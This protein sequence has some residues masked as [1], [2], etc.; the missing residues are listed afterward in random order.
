MINPARIPETALWVE[1]NQSA[2]SAV[3]LVEKLLAAFDYDA[4]D[5]GVFEVPRA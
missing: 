3:Q 5:R 4:T 1:A 2:K